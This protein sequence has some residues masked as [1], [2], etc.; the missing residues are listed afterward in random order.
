MPKATKSSIFHDVHIRPKGASGGIFMKYIY[1]LRALTW[2]I[3]GHLKYTF[4]KCRGT[5]RASE[6]ELRGNGVDV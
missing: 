1:V 2:N 4:S 3:D 6:I 5:Q